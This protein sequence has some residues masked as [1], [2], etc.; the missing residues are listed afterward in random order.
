VSSAAVG[1]WG[2]TISVAFAR[3]GP[4]SSLPPMNWPPTMTDDERR[5]GAD[6]HLLQDLGLTQLDSS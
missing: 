2:A 1:A 5:R 6:E 3:M 4:D